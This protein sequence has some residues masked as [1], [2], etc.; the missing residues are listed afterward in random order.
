MYAQGQLVAHVF[1]AAINGN[2]II[3]VRGFWWF[4]LI[5]PLGN[6]SFFKK[7]FGG[8]SATDNSI[9]EI[10]RRGLERLNSL[11]KTPGVFLGKS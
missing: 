3:K 11:A 10:C 6:H 2:L 4:G 5:L 7:K 8:H 1:L 9:M